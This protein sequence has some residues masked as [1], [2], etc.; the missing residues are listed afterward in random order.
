M[1]KNNDAK[2]LL[3]PPDANK[4]QENKK[5]K[6]TQA[7]LDDQEKEKEVYDF[8]DDDDDF[9]E[10]E[11]DEIDYDQVINAGNGDDVEMKDGSKG[12]DYDKK[13]W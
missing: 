12:E 3:A 8:I 2:N 13:L 9:E 1:S 6:M 11:N 10:F 4:T 7:I 5:R